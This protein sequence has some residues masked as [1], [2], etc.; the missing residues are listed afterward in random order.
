[1]AVVTDDKLKDDIAMYQDIVAMY[2]AG[3]DNQAV[4][5]KY[6]FYPD[7]AKAELDVL[8]QQ[9]NEREANGGTANDFFPTGA[10]AMSDKE[11]AQYTQDHG[12]IAPDKM[13]TINDFVAPA[14]VAD[15]STPIIPPGKTRGRIVQAACIGV[16]GLVIYKTYKAPP[17]IRKEI[18]TTGGVAIG[19]LVL[20]AEAF[21][22][23]L[24]GNGSKSKKF[25]YG[26]AALLSASGAYTVSRLIFKKTSGPSLK[27]AIGF[28][29]I[30]PLALAVNEYY[31]Y[32]K[33]LANTGY[34]TG[35]AMPKNGSA[36]PPPPFVL[37]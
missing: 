15:S 1:M 33:G 3:Q 16:A 6:G 10:L 29:V 2:E 21:G 12:I 31:Q 9:Y 20:M 37:F 32:K 34:N 5:D 35:V 11:L 36:A 30:V 8:M 28:G 17:A 18:L 26:S 19:G 23:A 14:P 13:S 4:V 22:S 25:I 27:I 7:N 24:S